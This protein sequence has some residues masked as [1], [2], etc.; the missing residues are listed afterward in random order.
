MDMGVMRVVA[1]ALL[2]Y[3]PAIAEVIGFNNCVVG[4]LP[5][6]WTIAMTHDGA[7]PQ[8]EIVRDPTAPSPPF[9]L[10]QVSRDSTAGRFPLAIWDAAKIR[11]GEVSVAFKTVNGNV[12]QA[13]GIVWRYRDSNN[14]Y[15]VRANAL[16]NNVVL[17]KV[18]NGIRLS[19]AP[20]GL[21]SRSYGV[22]HQIPRARWNTLKVVFKDDLF[23]VFLN[24]ERLFE[25]ADR[26]FGQA[27]K[28]GLWTKADSITYF[29]EFT[30]LG[31]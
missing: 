21:P 20:N 17:Y 31:K 30:I 3:I 2:L 15:I 23:T 27:G 24:G 14:Y 6:G 19:I 16:E 5:K 1:A 9:A 10:A 11:D 4:E 8:W 25:T 13:A 29:D 12:D 22:K 7:P 28:T 26:T 18:E